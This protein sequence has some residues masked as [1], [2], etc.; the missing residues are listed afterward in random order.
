MPSFQLE[1]T[2]DGDVIFH[3]KYG[4]YSRNELEHQLKEGHLTIKELGSIYN[5]NAFR[6]NHVLRSLNISYR[7]ILADTRIPNFNITPQMHQIIL[8]TLLGDAFMKNERSYMLGHSIHQMDYFYKVA[9][10][11][12]TAVS[13]VSYKYNSLGQSL[14]FWTNCHELFM[15]YADKFYS[16]GFQKKYIK[17]DSVSDLDPVG[18]AYWYMDDGKY[19]EYGMTLCTGYTKPEIDILI[20]VLKV[21]FGLE[22][23]SFFQDKIK[24]YQYIY[25]KSESRLQFLSLIDPYIIPS[26][27]YKITGESFPKLQDDNL[28]AYR[29]LEFCKNSGR[30]VRFVG[31]K[32]IEKIIQENQSLVDKKQVYIESIKKV[33]EEGKQLSRTQFRLEPSEVELKSLLQMGKTDKEIANQ[34]GFGRNRIA[35][36]RKNMG[37]S[38][39]AVREKIDTEKFPCLNV[40]MVPVEMICSNEYNPN[41]VACPEMDLLIL[42]ISED[43]LTQPIVVYFDKDRGKYIVIDGFHRYTVLKDHF[44]YNKIPVVVLQKSLNER[45]ASTIRHNRARGKHQVEL[46]GSLV[47]NLSERGWSDKTIAKHLGMEGEELL[48]LRQQVGCAKFLMGDDFNQAWGK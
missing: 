11:L 24:G 28:I 16:Q 29:H 23:S 42:S 44:K 22:A 2:S 10:G 33:M 32:K 6:I 7:N 35:Q 34:L 30:L 20:Q 26:M 46:M 3:N 39:K 40:K 21:N 43:G 8:G 19:G 1:N 38:R 48:R 5:L 13:T 37:I 9:E 4:V 12:N 47:K 17:I 41:K 45:M 27:R 18:L 31:H 15:P 14:N 36:L 25:I